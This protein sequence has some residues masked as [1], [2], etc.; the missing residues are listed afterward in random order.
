MDKEKP[1]AAPKL[2]NQEPAHLERL[3]TDSVE[4]DGLTRE[5]FEAA[6]RKVSTKIPADAGP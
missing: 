4:C 3:A 6:L 5:E 2:L 1:K